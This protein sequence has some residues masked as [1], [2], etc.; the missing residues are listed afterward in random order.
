VRIT[1]EIAARL[2][3]GEEVSPEEISAAMAEQE[4]REAAGINGVPE[5]TTSTKR[6][7]PAPETTTTNEWLPENL[8]TP[9]KRGK[10]QGKRK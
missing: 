7:S 8:T 5:P 1:P 9:K 3:R 6:V 4:R 10:G 2:K